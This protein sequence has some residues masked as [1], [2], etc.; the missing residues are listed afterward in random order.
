MKKKVSIFFMFFSFLFLAL[1]VFAQNGGST[2]DWSV[3]SFAHRSEDTIFFQVRTEKEIF[4]QIVPSG[5]GRISSA[6]EEI[7]I[8]AIHKDEEKFLIIFE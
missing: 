1:S 6:D 4:F 7:K 8:V 3:L 5:T 2:K